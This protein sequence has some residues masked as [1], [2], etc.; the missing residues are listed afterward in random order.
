MTK[1]GAPHKGESPALS[2]ALLIEVYISGLQL[3]A[4]AIVSSADGRR[5]R[6]ETG[7]EI[8]PGEKIK[9]QF[10]F[11]PSHTE[12]MTIDKEGLSGKPAGAVAALIE[13]AAAK[14]G[15]PYQTPDELRRV[16]EIQGAE[17]T[18]RV[19]ASNQSGGLKQWHTRY[20]Q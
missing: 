20:K 8:A 4:V 3:T 13:Q 7:G 15:A 19:M 12:L 5:C 17:I 6:I 18:A 14:L 2:R 1:G 10:Y 16:T 11:K 9:W